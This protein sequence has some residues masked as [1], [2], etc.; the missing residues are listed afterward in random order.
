MSRAL[1]SLLAIVVLMPG[2]RLQSQSRAQP[3]SN[4]PKILR[5][6]APVEVPMLNVGTEQSPLPGVEVMV[7]GRGPFRFGIETGARFLIITAD[8]AERAGLGT[9]SPGATPELHVD[10]ITVVAMLLG[11]IHVSVLS[12]APRGVDGLLGLPAFENLLLTIDYPHTR[13]RFERDSLPAADGA[14]ILPLQ[15]VS[16]FWGLPVSYA[17]HPMT[18]VLDTRSTGAFSLDPKVIPILPWTAEP[19]VV[20][21]AGGAGNPTTEIK[22]GTLNGNV[23]LGQYRITNPFLTLHQLPPDFPSEPRIGAVALKNFVLTLDQ[24]HARVRLT[25]D[26][27][28]RFALPAPQRRAPL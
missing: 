5:L 21:R 11:D 20:G 24:R 16:D 13:I 17:G 25:R 15:R 7:N 12:R 14:T 10:S 22:A 19:V 27:P 8:A 18:T 23:A 6:T 2:A 9:E 1:A 4:P 26:G 28:D 3:D